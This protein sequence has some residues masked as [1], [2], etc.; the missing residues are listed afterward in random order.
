MGT[1]AY[2]KDVIL[3]SLEQARMLRTGRFAHL[4]IEH[5]ADEIEDVGKS[6]KREFAARMGVLMAHLLKWRHQPERRVADG[7]SRRSWMNTIRNQRERIALAVKATPSLKASL[8][9]PDWRKL[10]W[11]DAVEQA[12]RETGFDEGE[13]G[14]S[15]PWPMEQVM[16]TD[17]LPD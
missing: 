5:L 17:F 12:A 11:L 7:P 14:E 8:R 6:E 1:A 2:D 10:A 13:F 9:D 3:W 16:L 15:C 4:D